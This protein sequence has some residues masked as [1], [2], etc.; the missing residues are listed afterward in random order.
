MASVEQIDMFN[1]LEEFEKNQSAAVMITAKVSLPADSAKSDI[2]PP[3]TPFLYRFADALTWFWHFATSL[4]GLGVWVN[5]YTVSRS[6]GGREEGGWC[7]MKFECERS[8]QVGFWEAESLRHHWET[9][10]RISHKWG[11]LY[12]KSGGQD[13]VVLIEKRRAASRTRCKPR[14]EDYTQ[15]IPYAL[16]Q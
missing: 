12:T 11:N 7:Y 13:V 9:Q 16:I 15:A 14:Y 8:Q 10:Y 2:L 1:F 5:V 4:F 3:R 6:F